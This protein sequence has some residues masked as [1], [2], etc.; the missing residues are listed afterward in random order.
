[1]AG[2]MRLSFLFCFPF[3]VSAGK[4]FD[5][6]F[7]FDIEDFEPMARDIQLYSITVTQSKFH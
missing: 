1:M 5:R 3:L 2:W 4:V 7:R 6:N